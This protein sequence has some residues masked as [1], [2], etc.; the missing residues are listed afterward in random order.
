[1]WRKAEILRLGELLQDDWSQNV[2]ASIVEFEFA[3]HDV[4]K[5]VLT[6]RRN[7]CL[8]T[9]SHQ[10][11]KRIDKIAAFTGNIIVCSFMDHEQD[12]AACSETRKSAG[13]FNPPW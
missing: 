10:L 13:C 11:M 9:S 5:Y 7:L 1:M 4:Q 2:I 6:L 3:G 8:N 12:R